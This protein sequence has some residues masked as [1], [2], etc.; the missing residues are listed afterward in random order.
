MNCLLGLV[1]FQSTLYT[2]NALAD[3]SLWGVQI[4]SAGSTLLGLV[5]YC[6][7]PRGSIAVGNADLRVGPSNVPGAGLGLFASN[8]LPR[9]TI[10]GRYPGTCLP[11][12]SNIGKLERYP[13]CT[14]YIWRFADNRFILDPT[15]AVGDLE[16]ACRGGTPTSAWLFDTILPFW[17]VPTDLCRINEPPKGFD[18]NV[19]TDENLEQRTVTFSVERDI[20]PGEELFVDYGPTYDRSGYG[21]PPQN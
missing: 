18:R 14:A 13:Q 9:G 11:L 2:S 16:D 3:S 1:L 12:E 5:T 8:P 10:L 6:D 17:T 21:P 7:R 4:A 20:L 15:N 19:L